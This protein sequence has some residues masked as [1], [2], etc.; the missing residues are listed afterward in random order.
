MSLNVKKYSTNGGPA[1]LGPR[2]RARAGGVLGR[3]SAQSWGCPL[4]SRAKSPDSWHSRD[5]KQWVPSW[6]PH[7]GSRDHRGTSGSLGPRMFPGGKEALG[8]EPH[9]P[10]SRGPCSPQL[11]EQ[12]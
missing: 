9:Q 6:S 11:G 3:T 10:L 2:R 4:C 12:L 8:C 7:P 5:L 1:G